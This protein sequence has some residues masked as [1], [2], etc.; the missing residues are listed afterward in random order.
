LRRLDDILGSR[1]DRPLAE[2]IEAVAEDV[3]AAFQLHVG[4]V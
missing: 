4:D 3:R 2:R 1:A